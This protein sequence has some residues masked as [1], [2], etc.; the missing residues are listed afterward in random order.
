M[1]IIDLHVDV[2]LIDET[3]LILGNAG[4]QWVYS[5]ARLI[6]EKKGRGK[7]MII[8]NG[9]NHMV[10]KPGLVMHPYLNSERAWILIHENNAKIAIWSVYM[11]AEVL[12][13]EFLVWN[14]ELNAMI[15]VEMETIQHKGYKVIL[16]G[17]FNGHV[18]NDE[19]GITGNRGD[20]NSKRHRLRSFVTINSLLLLN[21]NQSWCSGTLTR[22]TSNSVTLDYALADVGAKNRVNCMIID[23]MNTILS[24]SDH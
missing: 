19:D 9:I 13:N 3:H 14:K 4:P 23:E 20:I 15:K 10:W 21:A 22:L 8:R 24:H 17:D 18:G 11:A 5:K 7:L 12:Y 1:L 2:C 16:I 6:L